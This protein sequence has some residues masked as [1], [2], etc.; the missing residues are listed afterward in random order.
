M[1]TFSHR[2]LVGK[3]EVALVD[4]LAFADHPGE[5]DVASIA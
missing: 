4:A 2:H 1:T 5:I 3:N